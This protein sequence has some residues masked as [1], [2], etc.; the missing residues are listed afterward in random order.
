MCQ[1]SSVSLLRLCLVSEEAN[2]YYNAVGRNEKRLVL[3]LDSACCSSTEQSICVCYHLNNEH[4]AASLNV[5]VGKGL[6]TVAG[7]SQKVEGDVCHLAA[8]LLNAVLTEI[9]ADYTLFDMC[10]V[11]VTEVDN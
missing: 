10:G 1:L 6:P 9:L 2:N 11:L 3:T 8:L 5:V 7:L 4:Y